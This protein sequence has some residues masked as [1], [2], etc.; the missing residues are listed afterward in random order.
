MKLIQLVKELRLLIAELR[1]CA[2]YIAERK[3]DDSKKPSR[4]ADN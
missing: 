4:T 3:N 2:A 1:R